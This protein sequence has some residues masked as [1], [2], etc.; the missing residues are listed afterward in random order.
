MSIY[1][2]AAF[3][4]VINPGTNYELGPVFTADAG[5]II[6]GLQ[7]YRIGTGGTYVVS[8]LRLWNA[9]TSTQIGICTTINDSG[10]AGWQVSNMDSPATLSAGV[11]Y[12]CSA[13]FSG[14]SGEPSAALYGGTPSGGVHL[15]TNYRRYH[16]PSGSSGFPQNNDAG[17]YIG[18]DVVIGAAAVGRSQMV[19]AA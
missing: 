1:N 10:A 16:T 13:Y 14:G 11:N 3:S 5:T 12:C 8:V 19:V 15:A 9:D 4:G 2:G 7:W 18:V 6:S 17:S